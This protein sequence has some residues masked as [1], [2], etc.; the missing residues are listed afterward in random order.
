[1]VVERERACEEAVIESRCNQRADAEV[2]LKICQG[3]LHH[4]L[5]SVSGVAG[6]DLKR[7]IAVFM[8]AQVGA[9]LRIVKKSWCWWA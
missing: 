7:R 9:K 6:G 8:T 3:C 5:L 2:I 4:A 1:M